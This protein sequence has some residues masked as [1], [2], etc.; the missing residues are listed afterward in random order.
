MQ[1]TGF[2]FRRYSAEWDYHG[3]LAEGRVLR[4]E[5]IYPDLAAAPPAWPV[6]REEGP[7][8]QVAGL[9]LYIDTDEGLSGLFG[10]VSAE[11]A[12]IITGTL[13]PVLLGE[14]P[15]A[16]ERL[17]DRM[18]RTA[19]H[20]R[21][22]QTM[23][24]ISKVDLALWD[25]KGK[26]LGAPVY[27]LL[28]GPT[29]PANRA[30]ASM[31]G[32]SIE[33]GDAARRAAEAVSLGYAATK[34]FVRKGPA[35]GEAGIRDNLAL[36]AAVRGAVGADVEI[37]FDAWSSWS[38]PYTQRMAELAAPYRVW[39]FEEPVLADRIAEYAELRRTVRGVAIAGGEHEYTRWGI[40]ALLEAGAV[41]VM[42]ADP[43]W[44]GGLTELKKIAALCS[45]YG[46]PL[47]PHHGSFA[48]THL[49]ASED[50]TTCPLQEWLLQAG[51]RENVLLKCPLEAVDGAIVLPDRPG[52]G[53]EIADEIAARGE[54]VA[55]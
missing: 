28:G 39:W 17:W 27:E 30:Y 6:R 4:P 2:R 53:I 51:A 18:Y 37:M 7:P 38:V 16:V 11:E 47:I 3:A 43:T 19:I 26:A 12:R 5:D 13:A 25:L 55:L 35:D 44:A 42:Q 48:S 15:H 45:A 29:R 34:W 1:I 36:I 50:I 24:A 41:D 33:P 52:L 32:Y 14:N 23:M 21:K 40:R 10:P 31:L 22:G 46:V 8:Y 9:Y 49:I 20:G 54:D